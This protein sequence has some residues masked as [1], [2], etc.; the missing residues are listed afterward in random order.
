MEGRLDEW[1][2]EMQQ[3]DEALYRAVADTDTPR[4]DG[5][6]R[7]VS[8]AADHSK[9]SMAIALLMWASGR[10]RAR[11]A[12]RSGLQAVA[13]TS[14]AVNLI[15]KPLGGRHRPDRPAAEA[16]VRRHVQMPGSRSFP[17]GHTASAFAF[18]TAAGEA[19]PAAEAPLHAL[20]AVVGYSRVH[21]GVHYPGDVIAGALLGDVVA[22]LSLQCSAAL[23]RRRGGERRDGVLDR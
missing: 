7:G 22:Q 13:L 19:L 23:G 21:T 6:L 10:A 3:V 16:P 14:A 5:L 20:A 1:L 12:A 15:V 11:D 18:A 9:L 8:R 2:G 4:L 17:S